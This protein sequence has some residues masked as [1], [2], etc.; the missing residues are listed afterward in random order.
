MLAQHSS[1]SLLLSHLLR[2]FTYEILFFNFDHP[3]RLSTQNAHNLWFDWTVFLSGILLIE[4]T[5]WQKCC[6]YWIWIWFP[7]QPKL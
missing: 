7:K 1:M 2:K 3:Q 4:Q 5:R 6:W